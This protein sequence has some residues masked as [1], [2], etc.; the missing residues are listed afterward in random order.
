MSSTAEQ[1]G[2]N[3]EP[4]FIISKLHVITES[5]WPEYQAKGFSFYENVPN[6]RDI[7]TTTWDAEREFQSQGD[8]DIL[9]G[10]AFNEAEGRPL[11]HMPGIGIYV[12]PKQDQP[13]SGT[14]P[15]SS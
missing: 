15:A 3:S 10:E 8:V 7:D 12:G 1:P 2:A 11:A 5:N 9:A 6:V 14:G 4:N 13:S